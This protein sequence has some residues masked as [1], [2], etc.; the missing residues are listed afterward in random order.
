VIGYT[1]V[2]HNTGNVAQT[3]VTVTDTLPGGASATLAGPAEALT[4]NGIFEAN[5]TWSYTGSYTVTQADIN[6]GVPLVNTAHLVTNEVPGPTNAT[7]TTPVTRAPALIFTTTADKVTISAPGTITYEIK[8]ANTG[9]IDLTNVV[10]SDPF[11]TTGPT[12][13]SGDAAPVGVLNLSETWVYAATHTVT[14]SEIDAGTAL[15]NTAHVVTTEVPGP[16]NAAATTSVA[17][18]KALTITKTQT[19]GPNPATAQGQVLGYTIAV[20]NTGTT[21]QTGVTVTDTLPSGSAGTLSG[22]VETLTGN[23]IFEPNETWTYTGSYTV[24]QANIDADTSLVNTVRVITTQVPGPTSATATTPVAG[25]KALTITKTQTS[26]PNPAT[27]QGQVLGYTIVV[28]N[29]G[30]ATQTGVTLTDMLPGGSAGTLSGPVETL[31]ANGIFEPNETWTYTGSYTV[32]QANIDAGTALVNTARVV[33]TQVPGPTDAT[34]TTPVVSGTAVATTTAISASVNPANVGQ[35]ITFT[36]SVKRTSNNSAVTSGTVTF[37]EGAAT[38]AG[39]TALSASGQASFATAA[40]AVGSHTITAVYS[41]DATFAGS[42]GSLLEAVNKIAIEINIY[43]SKNPSEFL[44]SVTF[45]AWLHRGLFPVGGTVTFKD[46]ATILAASVPVNSL[47]LAFFSTPS[48]SV[49][50]HTISATFAGTATYASSTDSLSQVVNQ[51]GTSVSLTSSKN[52]SN[53]NQSVTFTATVTHAGNA[54]TTGNVTFKEGT[55]V[56]A[57]PISVSASGQASFTKSNLSSGTHV[58]TAVYSGTSNY[59]TSTGT[60]TQT[61]R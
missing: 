11:A 59:Q 40:L 57:G 50:I 33:T 25:T 10:V 37:K 18:T 55:T 36:A 44:D 9:N 24:T 29:T 7:A 38:L 43:S 52:P 32:T 17:G 28:H 20:H 46:G 34:A 16:T 58:I 61:V 47:G 19:S 53:R 6:A 48:L 27:A 42:S 35:S 31:T 14:Q 22:P 39:P 56:L 26:G 45:T 4:T 13:S 2:V 41:G 60:I 15:V 1:V 51:A 30:T 8:V 12:I 49:G 3:G 21:T 5:E 23:G 54:V